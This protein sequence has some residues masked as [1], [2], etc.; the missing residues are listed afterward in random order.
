MN[1]DDLS[2]D[3]QLA[4]ALGCEVGTVQARALAGSL[5]GVKFGRGW[6]FPREA[7]LEALNRQAREQAAERAKP[8]TPLAVS[9]GVGVPSKPGKR[10][11]LPVLPP[12]P[13]TRR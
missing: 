9:V 11:P 5:P 2:T 7:L 3:E 1:L 6:V 4:A 13:D 8:A 10:R 12:L